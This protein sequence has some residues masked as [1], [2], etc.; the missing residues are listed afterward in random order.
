LLNFIMVRL[1]AEVGP[2]NTDVMMSLYAPASERPGFVPFISRSSGRALPLLFDGLAPHTVEIGGRMI[3]RMWTIGLA[4]AGLMVCSAAVAQTRPQQ[5][6]PPPPPPPPPAEVR[7]SA[8]SEI[9]PSDVPGVLAAHPDAGEASEALIALA[10]TRYAADD[11]KGAGEALDAAVAAVETAYGA[12][13]VRLARPLGSRARLKID[14]GDYAA[15]HA[16]IDRALALRRA[17]RT[18]PDVDAPDA[19]EIATLIYDRAKAFDAQGRNEEAEVAAR[20]SWDI[21]RAVL[22]PVQE[23]TADSLNLYANT[24]S[25]QGRHAEADPAYRQVLGMY[26]VLHGPKDFHL[27][28]VLSNLGNSL[29]RTGRGREANPLYR[30]AVSVA[31]VSGDKVLLA[32]C[33]TNY[34]WYLHTQGDGVKA[35]IQFRRAL[36]LALTIVGPDHPFVGNLHGNIAFSLLDQNRPAEAE[37][38]FAEGLRIQVAGLGADSPD[39]METLG[40][41]ARTLARLDRPAEAEPLYLRARTIAATRLA[42]AHPDALTESGFYAGFLLDQ[43]RPAEAL[44]ELRGSLGTLVGQGSGGRDWRTSIKGAG[45]LFEQKV[46]ADWRLSAAT[47]GAAP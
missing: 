8:P 29:R 42:A 24:L 7:I 4:A 34:G 38:E 41:Y 2:A 37:P 39:L 31:E 13:D 35:E 30:R 44:A 21:R 40:G 5:P 33:L 16:D 12:D 28:I 25:A 43:D 26:E 1:L 6:P 23:K 46:A 19:A 47:A 32:Q 14:A 18:T 15:A 11:L 45:S 22:G 10:S 3:K 36:I 17:G 27:A 9:G 20:Q